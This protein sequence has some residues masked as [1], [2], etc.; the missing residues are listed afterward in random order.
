MKD[1]LLRTR[2]KLRAVYSI[3]FSSKYILID[4]NDYGRVTNYYKMD[5]LEIEYWGDAITEG[6]KKIDV[7]KQE[8]NRTIRESGIDG[9]QE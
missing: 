8:L 1:F 3:V 4:M 5:D 9:I 2:S 7:A 6:C